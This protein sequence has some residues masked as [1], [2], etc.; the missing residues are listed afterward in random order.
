[1]EKRWGNT[2]IVIQECPTGYVY[3]FFE[4]RQRIIPTTRS[5]VRSA[6]GELCVVVAALEIIA[7]L[8]CVWRERPEFM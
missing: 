2:S 7:D 3:N 4:T 6:T 5:P 8:V 1:M